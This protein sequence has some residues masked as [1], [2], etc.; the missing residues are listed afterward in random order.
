MLLQT[1]S[2]DFGR[3]GWS[4]DAWGGFLRRRLAQCWADSPTVPYGSSRR[5]PIQHVVTG[6]DY[7]NYGS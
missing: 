3:V 2:S 7:A 6:V 5:C 4:A 1:A